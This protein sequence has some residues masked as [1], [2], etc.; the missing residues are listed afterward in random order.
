MQHSQL[1]GICFQVSLWRLEDSLPSSSHSSAKGLQECSH[2]TSA[3]CNPFT[4][5]PLAIAHSQVRPMY[6]HTHRDLGIHPQHTRLVLWQK[7]PKCIAEPT[8]QAYVHTSRSYHFKRPRHNTVSAQCRR[9][10]ELEELHRCPVNGTCDE[11]WHV[12]SQD[13]AY[14]NTYTTVTYVQHSGGIRRYDSL[15]QQSFNYTVEQ[16]GCLVTFENYHGHCWNVGRT[17]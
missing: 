1:Y 2:T 13:Y 4:P 16:K 5:S 10:S 11:N 12:L 17:N 8:L 7:P 9:C 6:R 14:N 3:A 15:R